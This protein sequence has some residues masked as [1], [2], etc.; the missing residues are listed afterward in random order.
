MTRKRVTMKDIADRLNLS[1]NAVSLALNDKTGVGEETKRL[2]L[3]IAEEMGYL[4]QSVKYMQNY[5]NKNIC[6]LL[7][8]V[9]S[10]ILDFTGESCWE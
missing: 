4:D 6:V 5:S 8:I 9:F 10:E 3:N 2:I 7:K 1:I